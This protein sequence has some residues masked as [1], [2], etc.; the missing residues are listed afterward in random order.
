MQA[1]YRKPLYSLEIKLLNWLI[2]VLNG[3]IKRAT[4]DL[5]RLENE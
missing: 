3:R 1:K 2:E 5:V 4:D